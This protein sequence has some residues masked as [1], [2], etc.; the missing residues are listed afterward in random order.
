MIVTGRIMWRNF[1]ESMNKDKILT[2]E[3]P[4]KDNTAGDQRIYNYIQL[5]LQFWFQ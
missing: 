5:V 1:G 2:W 4:W 3:K